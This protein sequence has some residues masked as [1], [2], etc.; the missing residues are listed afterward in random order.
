MIAADG[1]YAAANPSI[2]P[3]NVLVCSTDMCDTAT[4]A[5][6]QVLVLT[7]HP[8]LSLQSVN[9]SIGYEFASQEIMLQWFQ[10]YFIN[11]MLHSDMVHKM[12]ISLKGGGGGRR[13]DT[14]GFLLHETLRITSF[15]TGAPI[16]EAITKLNVYM[17]AVVREQTFKFLS[18]TYSG[19]ARLRPGIVLLRYPGHG[20]EMEMMGSRCSSA[21]LLERAA[22]LLR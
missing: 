1:P 10:G 6:E 8:E 16:Y 22:L 4:T 15:F 20:W 11:E 14:A 5:A 17:P 12:P 18:V 9:G 2:P 7:S 19:C 3:A 21:R 13:F